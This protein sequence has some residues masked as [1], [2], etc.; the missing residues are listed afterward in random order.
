MAD[1]AESGE[2]VSRCIGYAE[3]ELV[4]VYFENIEIQNE[5]ITESSI[6]AKILLQ[7][8]ENMDSWEGTTSEL[9]EVLSSIANN[10]GLPKS[11]SWPT[12]PNSLSRKLNEL[13]ATLKEKGIEILR[14]YDTKT[15]GRIIRITKSGNISL[16]SSYCSSSGNIEN[17][18]NDNSEWSK[19]IVDEREGISDN[20]KTDGNSPICQ[21]TSQ[22]T[23]IN[24]EVIRHSIVKTEPNT[25]GSVESNQSNTSVQDIHNIANRLYPGSDIWVCKN[26]NERG[27]RWHILNH[28][29]NC[30]MN[31]KQ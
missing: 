16:I 25:I 26:C 10:S 18:H 8:L 14:E 6:V 20:T 11:K 2:I 3:Y 13:S 5:E 21:S 19:N 15:H 23:N 12:A 9:Y 31:K 7:F 29:P 17:E 27:D 4:E 1:F 30:K 24:N 22:Q 28:H